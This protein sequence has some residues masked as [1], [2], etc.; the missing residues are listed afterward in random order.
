MPY[1]PST[2]MAKMNWRKRRNK[3]A[4]KSGKGREVWMDIFAQ[5]LCC[6]RNRRREGGRRAFVVGGM[7]ELSGCSNVERGV[8]FFGMEK[9]ELLS[10]VM[11][12]L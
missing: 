7:E 2:A 3:F 1:S 8:S 4:T 6:I 9:M 10:F 5:Y 12:F 11:C